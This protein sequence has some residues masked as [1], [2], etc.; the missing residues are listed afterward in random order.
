MP[1]VPGVVSTDD[2]GLG[3]GKLFFKLDGEAG[4]RDLG[5]ASE[6]KVTE[7]VEK[8]DH[9]SSRGGIRKK[10]KSVVSQQDAEAG[11]ILDM[12]R[13]DNLQLWTIASDIL[14][15]TQTS[16]VTQ[17]TTVVTAHNLWVPV[18]GFKNLTS[19]VVK[20]TAETTTYTLGT[21]YE[22]DTVRGMLYVKS[23]GTIT[24]GQSVHVLYDRGTVARTKVQALSKN[25]LRGHCWFQANNP[26]GRNLDL[27][28]YGTLMPEGDLA[29]IGDDWMTMNFKMSFELHADYSDAPFEIEDMGVAA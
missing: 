17:N 9:Y 14:A 12:I 13:G 15:V 16:A 6:F 27:R 23:T 2:I 5:N 7:T 4:H 29:L 8:K 10:D 26:T 24:Q 25:Q 1:I 3:R 19:V 28:G 22:I 18:G 21:D 20:N 11:F